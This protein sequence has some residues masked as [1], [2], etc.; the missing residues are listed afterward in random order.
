LQLAR[1]IRAAAEEL[2]Y[3]PLTAEA[4]L[5]EGS[6]LM[7]VARAEEAEAALTAALK[8]ALVH[9]LDSVA[10]EAAARRVFALGEGLGQRV[11]ALAGEAVAEALADRTRDDGR[12]AAL[13]HNNLGAVYERDGAAGR[14]R[15]HYLRT[16][17][18][19]GRR[20]GAGD[21]LLAAVHH[22][23]AGLLRREGR[24]D[25]AREH[26]SQAVA[27]FSEM[28]GEQHP[29]VAHPIGGV[30]D[31]DVL[32]G[33]SD[34]AAAGYRRALLLMEATYGQQHLYL[35]HPLVGLGKVSLAA[36]ALDTAAVEFRRAVA[37]GEQLG[38]THSMYAEALIGL[39]ECITGTDLAEARTLLARAMTVYEADGGPKNP[40]IAAVAVRAGQLAAAANDLPA[41][42]QWFERV[43]ADATG[44]KEQLQSRS[45][46]ALGLARILL[47][48]GERQRACSLLL[49]ARVGSTGEA[50]KADL[51]ALA[52][53]CSR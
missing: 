26:Y 27:L 38:T 1:E 10:A 3:P 42:R 29:M 51:D 8:L 24:L 40:A 43:L 9:G 17:E 37:I 11:A 20:A 36:G 34:V 30:A 53:A 5:G 47:D 16:I 48:A 7:A 12:I 14:A 44:S 49:D 50:H 33:R 6:L 4:A 18:L 35:L 45:L 22:N 52:A 31:I 39:A 21:P 13:L 41:A 19:L 28:L 32:Q 2:H 25:D 23:L 15:E 46:A